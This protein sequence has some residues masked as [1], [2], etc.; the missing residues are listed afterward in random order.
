MAEI[1]PL[2][3]LRYDLSRFALEKVTA[4]PYDVISAE[5]REALAERDPENVVRLILPEGEG[6]TK[7][8]NAAKTLASMRERGVLVRDEVPGYYRYDQTFTA[9]VAGGEARRITRKGFLAAVKLSP[10]SERV[11]LPHER[12]LSGPKEDRLKLFRATRTNL[13][14]GFMLYRDPALSLDGPLGLARPIAEMITPDGVVHRLSKVVDPE[15][16]RAITAKIAESALLIADGHHRYETAVRYAGEVSEAHPG[17]PARAEHRYFMVFLSNGDDPGL[18][19]F[20]T[21]R[22]VHSLP[23]FSFDD[24]LAGARPLFDVT[25]LGTKDT[26]EMLRDLDRAGKAGPAFVACAKDGRA[27]LL[28]LRSD[29]NLAAHPA[30]AGLVPALQRTD[31]AVLHGAILESLCGIT[32]E[33][34]AAKTNLYYPQDAEKAFTDLLGGKGDVLF[35]MNPTPPSVVREVAEAGEVMPQ[36]STFFFPKVLTGLTIHTLDPAREVPALG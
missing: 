29:A 19:V 25:M 33:A 7:Y 12:T 28:C 2:T 35:L 31:I 3:P 9:A 5:E 30:L 13:S 6:D 24:L 27:A 18:V 16:L 32:K 1:A 15:A 22:H 4:P 34:Q 26:R 8:G 20:P 36:K 14:P 23:S 21:H 11:V 10:F 17:A